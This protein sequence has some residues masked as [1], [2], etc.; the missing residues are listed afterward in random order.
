M[1][2]PLSG[3]CSCLH[4]E[5]RS[6]DH[7]KD[8]HRHYRGL[9]QSV[10]HWKVIARLRVFLQIRMLIQD[11]IPICRVWFATTIRLFRLNEPLL[12]LTYV[13]ITISTLA[14]RD[15]VYIVLF[16]ETLLAWNPR[17]CLQASL[18]G[19]VLIFEDT[20]VYYA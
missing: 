4:L 10:S 11:K 6:F 20:L 7:V 3:C 16:L 18:W 12:Y 15:P 14:A 1:G 5:S 9:F 13:I 19:Y 17:L 8:G 2:F